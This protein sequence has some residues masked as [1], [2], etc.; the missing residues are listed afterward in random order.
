LERCSIGSAE[1]IGALIAIL[2]IGH[3]RFSLANMT[4]IDFQYFAAILFLTTLRPSLHLFFHLFPL[5]FWWL[6]EASS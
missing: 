1:K 5:A 4:Y 3:A 6:E 2:G